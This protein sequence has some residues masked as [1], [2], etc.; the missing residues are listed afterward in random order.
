MWRLQLHTGTTLDVTDLSWL[1]LPWGLWKEAGPEPG[2]SP[3]R[4]SLLSCSATTAA[5]VLTFPAG[6]A[7]DLPPEERTMSMGNF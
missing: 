5:W 4:L 6:P 2:W 7:A 3:G 1:S